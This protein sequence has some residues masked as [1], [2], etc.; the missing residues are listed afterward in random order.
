M[1]AEDVVEVVRLLEGLGIDVWLDGGWGVDALLGTQTRPH[2]DLDLVVQLEDV[3]KL[4]AALLDRG[5][6]LVGG[7]PRR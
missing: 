2:D 7:A 3:P 6:I 5:Y 4:R 1:S